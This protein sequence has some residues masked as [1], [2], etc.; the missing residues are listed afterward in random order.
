[1]GR[2]A[3]THPGAVPLGTSR[4]LRPPVRLALDE[5]PW[6]FPALVALQASRRLAIRALALFPNHCVITRPWETTNPWAASDPCSV[7]GAQLPVPQ[8]NLSPCWKRQDEPRTKAPTSA[9][10]AQQGRSSWQHRGPGGA[11]GGCPSPDGRP[12]ETPD[13]PEAAPRGRSR[14]QAYQFYGFSTCQT[15]H[16]PLFSHISAAS[17]GFGL[18]YFS[19][20]QS[21]IESLV[22]VFFIL[23]CV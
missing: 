2:A 9:W 6:S 20:L 5:V 17:L 8:S 1:M 22:H 15:S 18:S 14:S 19:S 7:L 4:G 16:F 23:S 11:S 10:K 12:G 3:G 21:G 13:S